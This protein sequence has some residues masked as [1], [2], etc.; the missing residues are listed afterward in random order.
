[1]PVPSKRSLKILALSSSSAARFSHQHILLMTTG[2]TGQSTGSVP[3]MRADALHV[4]CTR[5]VGFADVLIVVCISCTISSCLACQIKQAGM[6]LLNRLLHDISLMS[7]ESII[8]HNSI[9]YTPT[10]RL[11]WQPRHGASTTSKPGCRR[12]YLHRHQHLCQHCHLHDQPR[13]SCHYLQM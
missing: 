7:A 8:A 9:H 3:H 1:M 13:L 2:M 11:Q 4:V 12:P 10:T 5:Q 6:A